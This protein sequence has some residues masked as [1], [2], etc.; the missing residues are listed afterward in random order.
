MAELVRRDDLGVI[1]ESLAP[2]D[3]ARA[4]ATVIDV[5]AEVASARRARV[6]RVAA[7]RYSWPIAAERYREVVTAALA[8]RQR[9]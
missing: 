4:I 7:E 8:V 1:A 3:L 9:P 5:P 2:D 6:A